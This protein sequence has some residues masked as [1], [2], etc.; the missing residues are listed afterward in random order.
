[1]IG[2]VKS[3]V[4]FRKK[5]DNLNSARLTLSLCDKLLL[6]LTVAIKL[7]ELAFFNMFSL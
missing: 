2:Y 6:T 4:V 5:A 1:M 7:D 3:Y